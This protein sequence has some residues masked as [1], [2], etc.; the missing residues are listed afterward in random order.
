MHYI[1]V[2]HPAAGSC[3]AGKPKSCKRAV[4]AWLE[5]GNEVCINGRVI[6]FYEKLVA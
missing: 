4:W 6:P 5:A 1:E 3:G 2:T